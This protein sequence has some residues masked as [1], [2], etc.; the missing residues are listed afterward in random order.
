VAS[1]DDALADPLAALVLAA[2]IEAPE[3][4]AALEARLVRRGDDARRAGGRFAPADLTS[5]WH[6]YSHNDYGA[7]RRVLAWHFERYRE[8]IAKL[9]AR[10]D[11]G[12]VPLL[13]TSL[14]AFFSGQG[15]SGS[16]ADYH[17]QAFLAGKGNG[18]Y[19]TGLT[20]DYR[21]GR[22]LGDLWLMILRD[23][24]VDRATFGK[25]SKVM[26]EIKI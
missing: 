2:P 3:A 11:A 10:T 1:E 4:R 7:H 9:K 14:L 23:F 19:R 5:D 22:D 6:S 20:H 17:L 12:G 18:R 25:G 15:D 21:N 26:S 16:H 13:D 24:G 8:L